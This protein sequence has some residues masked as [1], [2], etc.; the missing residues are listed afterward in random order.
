V[1][2]FGVGGALLCT[3]VLPG[4]ARR[5]RWVTRFARLPFHL[6]GPPVAVTGI[7]RLPA[8]QCI[9]VANHASYLD[10]IILQA[11]L[12]PRFAYVI[13]GEM[14]KI[15]VAGFL[16]RRIGA[17]FVDRFTAAASSDAR[18]LLRAAEGG[19]SLAFFPEGTFI[20]ERGLGPFRAGAF[21]AAIRY[22]LPV[23]PVI[24]RGSRA[25]F[26]HDAILPRY[27]P[28]KI[29]ILDPIS[30][31]THSD[32]KALAEAARQCILTVLDEPDLQAAAPRRQAKRAGTY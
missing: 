6:A 26:P 31:G 24:I 19:E 18:T 8:S 17:R 23:V 3:L 21:A 16:L 22:G 7:E 1:F 28:L 12:P 5:R 25:V 30:A 14:Q 10:G 11:F 9:V 32:S 15:P 20:G 4:L 29:D 13:K 2:L 27:A